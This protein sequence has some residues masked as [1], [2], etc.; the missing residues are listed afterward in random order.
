MIQEVSQTKGTP[1]AKDLRPPPICTPTDKEQSESPSESPLSST[2]IA[3]VI[4]FG[5]GD[6]LEAPHHV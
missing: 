6:G 1:S 4:T 3:P 5:G 2:S